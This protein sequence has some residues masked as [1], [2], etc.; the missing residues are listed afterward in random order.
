MIVDQ[1]IGTFPVLS[2]GGGG[3]NVGL[4]SMPV[5]FSVQFSAR[6]ISGTSYSTLE[7]ELLLNRKMHRTFMVTGRTHDLLKAKRLL[8]K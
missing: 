1:P 8:I 4:D 5:L 7:A 2:V 3:T 6:C